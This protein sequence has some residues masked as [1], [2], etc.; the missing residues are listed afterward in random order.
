MCPIFFLGFLGFSAF[1]SRRDPCFYA[2]ADADFV[3]FYFADTYC[4]SWAPQSKN[5]DPVALSVI[6]NRPYPFLASP[7]SDILGP[8]MSY[9]NF[10]TKRGFHCGHPG[11]V[12]GSIELE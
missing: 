7:V 11:T 9:A 5:R 6:T 12:E 3:Y 4:A 8:D 10:H 1:S 2:D